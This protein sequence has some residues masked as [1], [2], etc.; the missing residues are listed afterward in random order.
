MLG[1]TKFIAPLLS[2]TLDASSA[3]EPL[4]I[5]TMAWAKA[6]ESLWYSRRSS[7]ARFFNRSARHAASFSLRVIFF[8]WE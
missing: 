5:A 1:V 3:H 2:V 6:M 7:A 4:R 8:C